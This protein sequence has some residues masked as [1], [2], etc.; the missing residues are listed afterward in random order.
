[1]GTG[2]SFRPKIIG[3]FCAIGA[4]MAVQICVGCRVFSTPRI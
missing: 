3:F 1:M 2:G 4:A